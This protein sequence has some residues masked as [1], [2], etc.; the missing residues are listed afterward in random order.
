MKT[1][2]IIIAMKP[3]DG[4]YAENAIK[5]QVAGINVDQSRVGFVSK[6]DERESCD[7][8]TRRPIRGFSKVEGT[9][10]GT[11]KGVGYEKPQGR[12]PANVIHDGSESI[13][14]GFP[15][16]K[17]GAMKKEVAGYEA[18]SMFFNG[19]SG[20]SNQHGDEGNASRFFKECK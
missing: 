16:T 3:L 15:H 11:S 2:Q 17:S 6:E 12:F 8:Q 1:L 20:P 18:D 9:L 5:H 10:Y 14:A 4:N 19:R 7:K 13:K